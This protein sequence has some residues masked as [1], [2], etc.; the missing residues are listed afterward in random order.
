VLRRE[1]APLPWVLPCLVLIVFVVLRPIYALFTTARRDLSSAG[2][3]RG[4]A[5]WDNFTTLWDRFDLWPIIV[6]TAVWVVV[7]VAV[8]LLISLPLAQFLD[9]QFPG[10]R[11][12]RYALIFPWAASVLMTALVFRWMLHAFYGVVNR[13]LL[14]LNL[15]DRGIDWLGDTNKAMV[16]MMFVGV[17]VS[18]PFTTYVVLAGLQTVPAELHEAAAIDG[19]QPFQTWW[20][21]T[22][23]QLRPAILVA[24]LVNI[25]NVFNS[26]PIIWAMTQGGPAFRTS[27]TTLFMYK[28]AIQNNRLGPSAAMAIVNLGLVFLVVIAFLRVSRWNES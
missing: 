1:A 6:R 27:T 16:W 5:G 21:V 22:L 13:V 17:F 7:V 11:L 25:I 23:P 26:F 19:A 15:I 20:R 4:S 12:V 14:D 28:L 2:V 18:V 24:T 8:T 9:K 3:D 10:R